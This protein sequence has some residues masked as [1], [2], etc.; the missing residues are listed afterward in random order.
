MCF[1]DKCILE[2]KKIEIWKSLNGVNIKSLIFL[3]KE[4]WFLGI[5]CIRKLSVEVDYDWGDFLDE[6]IIKIGVLYFNDVKY[7]L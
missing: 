7:K 4:I 5:L 2:F 3:D 1:I 6:I